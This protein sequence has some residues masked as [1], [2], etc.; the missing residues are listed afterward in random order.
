[1]LEVNDRVTN[2]RQVIVFS[3]D[4]IYH[5]DSSTAVYSSSHLGQ[6]QDP[7]FVL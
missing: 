7:A 1:M 3:E 4:K 2:G 6:L 5:V